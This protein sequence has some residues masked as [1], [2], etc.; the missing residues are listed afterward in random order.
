MCIKR[1]VAMDGQDKCISILTKFKKV[2]LFAVIFLSSFI[3][4][5]YT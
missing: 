1:N 3:C 2:N 4:V 5:N